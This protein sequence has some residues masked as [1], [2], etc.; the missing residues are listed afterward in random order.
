MKNVY[1]HPI[2]TGGNEIV[3]PEIQRA[4]QLP[5]TVS[6]YGA[7][8][9]LNRYC[10]RTSEVVP[11]NFSWQ[12]GWCCQQRQEIDP[13]LLVKEPVIEPSK[14]YLVARQDEADYLAANGLRSQAIG[15]PF[16][17]AE[18]LRAKR[19]PNSLLI[20]PA[21]SLQY[22]EHQWK[23]EAYANQI[24]KIAGDFD[25]VVACVHPA[26]TSKGYWRPQ[27]EAVGI[28]CVEGADAFDLNGLVRIKTLL[29]QFEFVTTNMLGSHVVYAAATGARVSIF[30]EYAEYQLD[31]FASSEFYNLHPHVLEPILHLHSEAYVKRTYPQ[32]VCQPREGIANRN[33]AAI[34]IG[35]NNQRSPAELSK[36]FGW[37]RASI[38]KRRLK[39]WT[40][41]VSRGPE[42]IVKRVMKRGKQSV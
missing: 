8:R 26:C 40:R 12:H 20:M 24:A 19:I 38:V 28:E 18:P 10:R 32:F 34:E 1:S 16:V 30:G 4:E 2:A 37:D 41:A 14:T 7:E 22:T 6:F 33:W 39:Q 42:Q 5:S 11:G 3:L 25:R 17:Y 23:F 36:L 15:L 13:V 21:H 29:S 9:V 31:D 27:F 35:V